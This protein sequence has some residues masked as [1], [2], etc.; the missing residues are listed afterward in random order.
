MTEQHTSQT[1]KMICPFCGTEL[2]KERTW[3]YGLPTGSFFCPNCKC[4]K[5]DMPLDVDIWQALIDDKKAQDALQ[6]AIKVLENLTEIG[7]VD[8]EI[9]KIK[10]MAGITKQV[11]E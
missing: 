8:L 2:E 11:K 6:Y 1:N 3:R 10:D 7:G 5:G 9:M 4:D